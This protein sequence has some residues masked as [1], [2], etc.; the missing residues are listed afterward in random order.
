MKYW[1]LEQLVI[2]ENLN[3]IS[4][5]LRAKYIHLIM[6]ANEHDQGYIKKLHNRMTE[7]STEYRS[8][9]MHSSESKMRR[10]S[11]YIEELKILNQ[12]ERKIGA[13]KLR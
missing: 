5:R 12:D 6:N 9:F 7:I 1:M 8:I 13:N 3:S 11:A 2:D 4:H 10:I